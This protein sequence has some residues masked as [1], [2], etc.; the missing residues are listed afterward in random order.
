MGWCDFVFYA[1]VVD[2]HRVQTNILKMIK[3]DW[4]RFVDL[5]SI[6]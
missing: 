2:I 3:V 1:K 4:F 5:L 6:S